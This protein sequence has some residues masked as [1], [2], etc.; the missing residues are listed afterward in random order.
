[1]KIRTLLFLFLISLIFINACGPSLPSVEATKTSKPQ[2]TSSP[3]HTSIPP[4]PTV[5]PFL[6]EAD[7]QPKEALIIGNG[8]ITNL[9]V[10][11]E[12]NNFLVQTDVGLFIY[13]LTSL[14]RLSFR[15]TKFEALSFDGKE[16]YMLIPYQ[17]YGIYANDLAKFHWDGKEIIINDQMELL[18]EDGGNL[19][20][21]MAVVSPKNSFI[22]AS[23]YDDREDN[24][25]WIR[26]DRDNVGLWK[27]GNK[28]PNTLFK[29]QK[30][31]PMTLAF[32]PDETMIA[33][34]GA[35]GGGM[36]SIGKQN[37]YLA[38]ITEEGLSIPKVI[39]THGYMISS[40]IRFSPDSSMLISGD[41]QGEILIYNIVDQVKIVYQLEE[42]EY[43]DQDNWC[44]I[45][46]VGF[47]NNNR[48]AVTTNSGK[49]IIWNIETGEKEV[50][51]ISNDAVNYFYT[52][53]NDTLIFSTYGT[54]GKFK[55]SDKKVELLNSEF[56]TYN[57]RNTIVGNH[58]ASI[59]RLGNGEIAL[60]VWDLDTAVKVKS[61]VIEIYFPELPEIFTLQDS[62]ILI[63]SATEESGTHPI[64]QLDSNTWEV[65][66]SNLENTDVSFEY[67]LFY[68]KALDQ[69]IT[70]GS[71]K[72]EIV[73]SGSD[74]PVFSTI[75]DRKK[76]LREILDLEISKDGTQVFVLE[77]N[78]LLQVINLIDPSSSKSISGYLRDN[79]VP[80]G[81]DQL[82]IYGIYSWTHNTRNQIE[83]A[84]LDIQTGNSEDV[85]FGFPEDCKPE[86]IE[87]DIN[88][89]DGWVSV[90]CDDR[91]LVYDMLEDKILEEYYFAGSIYEDYFD[92][93][94]Q[95]FPEDG[96][97]FG[98]DY[99]GFL[100]IQ[101]VTLP[102]SRSSQILSTSPALVPDY[103]NTYEIYSGKLT[104]G[105]EN[106]SWDSVVDIYSTQ[107]TYL[108]KPSIKVNLNNNGGFS[109][110]ID[111][112]DAKDFT[113]LEF[114]IYQ[115]VH[116]DRQL[117]VVILGSDD[118]EPPNNLKININ[119]P[120]F[121]ENGF[122]IPDQWVRV[123]IPLSYLMDPVGIIRRINLQNLSNFVEGDFYLAEIRL[124]GSK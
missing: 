63:G 30:Y 13:D 92:W 73:M 91:I 67:G 75:D 18:D 72:Y 2:P 64:V 111:S 47:I 112:F 6:L 15:E 124:V 101:K 25:K 35:Q 3:V 88:Y 23:V 17:T 95:F 62:S 19:V 102:I 24:P 52:I 84:V 40:D 33:M 120:E 85:Q 50:N 28:E 77:N 27:E 116:A 103:E 16:G 20:L 29:N 71:N 89:P 44:N 61:S 37:I 74:D 55:L 42:D 94:Y 113:W 105:W 100:K 14:E 87:S 98:K 76:T 9:F 49:L 34:L 36:M 8:R 26:S 53:D 115:A 99:A 57:S 65:K 4:T 81:A 12:N 109:L 121:V 106:Y 59:S 78:H 1:M 97:L 54:V 96:Y 32:S 104:D 11:K 68:S 110:F 43:V 86:K 10:S 41:C 56:S 119:N 39:F 46:Q 66:Q 5:N 108:E 118:K 79:I 90:T 48:A 93:Y 22:L 60:D 38:D 21:P 107:V 51:S 69:Y 83:T 45:R 114:S 80:L 117:Q 58:L 7:F 122:F 31:Y 82:L 123:R 70:V